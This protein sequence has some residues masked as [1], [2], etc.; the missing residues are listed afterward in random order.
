MNKEGYSSSQYARL[1]VIEFTFT[2]NSLESSTFFTVTTRGRVPFSGVYLNCLNV[3]LVLRIAHTKVFT[4][5]HASFLK[6]EAQSAS[7]KSCCKVS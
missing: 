7:E 3:S 1:H 4:G 5:L 6:T 2:K